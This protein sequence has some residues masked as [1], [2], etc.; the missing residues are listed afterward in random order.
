MN[1]DTPELVWAR[2]FSRPERLF[3]AIY[4]LSIPVLISCLLIYF[5]VSQ[6]GYVALSL[7]ALGV[8]CVS[9]RFG[10]RRYALTSQTISVDLAPIG[11]WKVEKV[12]V[13][14]RDVLFVAVKTRYEKVYSK[15][16][17]YHRNAGPPLV[18][19]FLTKYEASAASKIL[20]YYGEIKKA[21]P[22]PEAN[23]ENPEANPENE[24]SQETLQP[25]QHADRP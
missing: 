13:P 6:P 17:V 12:E 21:E 8:V 16:T 3:L 20:A 14:L 22:V 9:H 15:A 10:R 5:H 4:L 25:D 19:D 2:R 23:P 24:T 7:S 11:R 1:N 18:L